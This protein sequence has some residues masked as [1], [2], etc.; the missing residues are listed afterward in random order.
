[1]R[2]S[3]WR[4]EGIVKSLP[5]D[6]LPAKWRLP[7]GVGYSGPAVANGHVYLTDY[8]I[9]DGEI[10]NNP[11]RRIKLQGKERILCVNADN[12]NPIWKHE[13]SC[14]YEVSF[15]SGPR[16]TPTVADG[17][18]YT[19][20][21]M[22][23]LR[24]VQADSGKLV[25]QKDL[26]KEYKTETPV[27]GF[28]GHPLVDG[29]K[30]ICLVGG[31][32]SVAVALDKETGKEIWRSL[33]ARE[34]GYCPPMIV[35]AGGT[36]QL[37]IW[38]AES[39]NGLNPETGSVYWTVPLAPDYGMSIATPRRFGNFLFASGI[40]NKGA[41]LRLDAQSPKVEIVWRGTSKTAVYCANSSPFIENDVIYGVCRQGELRAV[42]LRTGERLW[43]TYAAT[44]GTRRAN[45]ATAFIVKHAD[46]FFLANER[47]ELIIAKLT[48][49]GYEELS[50][51]SILKPTN[52]AMGRPVVWSHPAFA[53]QCIY[54]RNDQELVCVS[55]AAE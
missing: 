28:T 19:L 22:G 9:A 39:I 2:D 21:A 7:V 49:K 44:S 6:P 51:A 23:D 41:L 40:G 20:G 42:D 12:G 17:K 37:I 26:K 34:P 35:E 8:V 24:C 31:Q 14:R 53:N 54:A 36:R 47:G 32:G 55:L 10:V 46:R 3:V 16:T 13:Y 43:E 52:E 18:V 15:P 48:P 33:S 5:S 1:Q 27:W 25:W 45:Y 30:L 4:E 38:H 11:G 50:R 29:N